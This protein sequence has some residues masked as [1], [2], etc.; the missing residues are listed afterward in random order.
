M[1]GI[2]DPEKRIVIVGGGIIGCC[3]AYYLSRHPSFDPARHKITLIESSTIAGGSSGKAGGLVAKW[4]FPQ[5]LSRVSFHLHKEL[6]KEYDGAAKWGY[7]PVTCGEVAAN[8]QSLQDLAS[9]RVTSAKNTK[10]GTP[11]DLDWLDPGSV[12]DYDEVGDDK[13]TAQV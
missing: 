13:I 11:R 5:Q 6:A 12:T 8:G 4:A 2:Q 1:S 7:R 10:S 3:S 9:E